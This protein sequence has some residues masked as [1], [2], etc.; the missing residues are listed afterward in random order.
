M[1]NSE[2]YLHCETYELCFL[3]VLRTFDKIYL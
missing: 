2:A 3:D 1:E